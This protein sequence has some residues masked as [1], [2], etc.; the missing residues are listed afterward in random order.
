[1]AQEG[2]SPRGAAQPQPPGCSRVCAVLASGTAPRRLARPPEPVGVPAPSGDSVRP[3]R[4][5]SARGRTAQPPPPARRGPALQGWPQPRPRRAARGG[6]GLRLGQRRPSPRGAH[7]ARRA[8]RPGAGPAQGRGGRA[9]RPRRRAPPPGSPPRA[10]P[11]RPA[12]PG[13]RRPRPL[14]RSVAVTCARRGRGLGGAPAG[15]RRR[16]R[17]LSE[18]EASRSPVAASAPSPRPSASSAASVA[19]APR[20]RPAACAATGSPA[21]AHLPSCPHR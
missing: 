10:P 4:T 1:M 13:P 16:T 7:P 2:Y 14:G 15:G 9:G 21:G 18:Q 8:V 11:A 19:A 3:P 5:D 20:P 17:D 12:R 6:T